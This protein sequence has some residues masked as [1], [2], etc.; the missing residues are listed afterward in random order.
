MPVSINGNTGITFPDGSLQTAAASPLVLRNRIINGDMRIDQRNA[1]ASVTPTNG[2]FFLDRF[3]YEASQASKIT[4]QQNQGAVT[5]PVGFTNYLGLTS[6]SAYS[7]TSSDIFTIRQ[8]IEGFNIADLGWGTADAQPVT[9][10]FWVRSSLTGTFGVVVGNSGTTRSYPFTYTIT[11]ANTWEKKSVTITGDTTG[12]WLTNNGRGIQ[13]RFGLGVGSTYNGTAGAWT[14]S[15]VYGVTGATSVVGT[16]G[17]TFYIT[18]VQLE[19]N[20]TAT[21]FERRMYGQE[22][23]LC[24]RY[25]Y[26][27][28]A[29]DTNSSFG[30]GFNDSTTVSFSVLNFPVTMRTAPSALEQTGTASDYRIRTAGTVNTNCSAVPTFVGSTTESAWTSY[31]VASGLT[32]GQGCVARAN[33][34]S[35]FLAW[36]AEL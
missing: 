26:K 34:T 11:A 10:S 20:T 2:G 18:G 4:S 31:T 33:S 28:K 21:P 24:Q 36:G 32:A 12:T 9:L 14:T 30:S 8:I 3:Q 7:I 27:N 29:I 35:A 6:S 15:E 17:A 19:R 1:G 23:A 22:L 25:Y 5:P 13:V 16:N